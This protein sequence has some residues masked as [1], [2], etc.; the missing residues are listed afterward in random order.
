MPLNNL[1]ALQGREGRYKGGK[2]EGGRKEERK[3]GGRKPKKASTERK[4][5]NNSQAFP[6]LE[7]QPNI[8][9]SQFTEI[10]LFHPPGCNLK[11]SVFNI[12]AIDLDFRHNEWIRTGNKRARHCNLKLSAI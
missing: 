5:Q 8:N 3:K 2:E 11:S 10:A 4:E 1:E 7:S 12:Q 9:S 6:A